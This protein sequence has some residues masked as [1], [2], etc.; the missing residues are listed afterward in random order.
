[1]PG[2]PVRIAI[3][4]AGFTGTVLAVHLL[5]TV[6]APIKI[7]LFDRR[8]T[9]GRGLAYSAHNP[10]HLLNTRVS[11]MSV[12]EDDPHHFI[13]WL[14]ANDSIYG[15][16][17][18]VPPSGHAFVS[19]ATYGA[20]VEDVFL[21][22]VRA[23]E[24]RRI[25]IVQAVDDVV[26]LQ[27]AGDS[28][29]LTLADRQTVDVDFAI[30][31][32][33]NF[34]PNPPFPIDATLYDSGRCIID[35]WN[36][37]AIGRIGQHDSV[38]IVGTG[39]TMVDVAIDLD[40]RGHAGPIHA[41]SRH[42]LLPLRH[43]LTRS[44]PLFLDKESLPLSIAT[45]MKRVRREIRRAAAFEYDWR[46]AMDALRP[47][48]QDIWITMPEAER[49]R[50]LRHLRP[51]WDIHRHRMAPS[52]ADQIENWRRSSRLTIEAGRILGATFDDGQVHVAYRPRNC[53][54]RV[55]AAA[56]WMIN[57]AGPEYDYRRVDHPLV[58]SLFASDIARADSLALGLDLSPRSALIDADGKA[59]RRLFALGPPTRGLLWESTAVPDI[60]KQC[61][62]FARQLGEDIARIAVEF[63]PD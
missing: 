19:R 16:T 38:V 17:P 31:C 32:F 22:A 42:G 18:G 54:D 14:W 57:C 36:E 2:Q 5:R 28:V 23:A 13:R 53:A 44:Y 3:I 1:M 10:R 6:Q 59:S 26:D 48:I 49:R 50:F 15:E 24:D 34:P 20:Y 7:L 51:Y 41:L 33:G 30:L 9:F 52:I 21:S 40:A 12:F 43:E 27:P 25:K 60:R 11:N 58:Q 46:C 37:N 62:R 56:D 61:A 4:G 45:L 47:I 35:P 8:G 55:T 39:L 63:P 29:T